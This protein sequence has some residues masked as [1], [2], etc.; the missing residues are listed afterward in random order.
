M[1]A[2]GMTDPAF[3][4]TNSAT[5][6]SYRQSDDRVEDFIATTRVDQ[7][8]NQHPGTFKY[9]QLLNRSVSLSSYDS[10]S[11]GP[12]HFVVQN[13]KPKASKEIK[14]GS[15]S[16]TEESDQKIPDFAVAKDLEFVYV[17]RNG[18]A[19]KSHVSIT[20]PGPV[21]PK[22]AKINKLD[23]RNLDSNP[24]ICTDLILEMY[25]NNKGVLANEINEAKM[26]VNSQHQMDRLSVS[27]SVPNHNRSFNSLNLSPDNSIMQ[28]DVRG[29][30]M[31]NTNMAISE[32]NNLD[33]SYDHV[34]YINIFS[35]LCCWCF[36]LTGICSIIYARLT[37]KYFNRR[38][39]VQA[40]KYLNKSEW[41]L[42]LT[43]FFGFTLISIGFCVLEFYWFKNDTHKRTMY[44]HT[45]IIPRESLQN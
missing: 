23:M 45:F 34:K 20:P 32:P 29:N 24:V 4:T 3:L 15:K 26:N 17:N 42:I 14:Q 10:A 12:D 19:T 13:Q 27:R 6:S 16:D 31:I 22:S 38:D 9:T 2:T 11:S 37:K 25:K 40:K 39:L 43:F 7:K 8:S 33:I 41:F 44:P 5:T 36:P 21:R 18:L 30:V 28:R 1:F 35:F